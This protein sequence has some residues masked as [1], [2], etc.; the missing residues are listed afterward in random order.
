MADTDNTPIT[1]EEAAQM[2]AQL[3]Q[4]DAAQAAAVAADRAAKLKP[5]TDM[6]AADYWTDLRANIGSVAKAMVDESF[7]DQLR[8]LDTI[9]GN[10]AS[11][12]AGSVA[13][14]APPAS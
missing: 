3:Q 5:L 13:P 12:V 9:S 1:D 14:P 8:A 4:Y 11:I 6:L 7:Y 2:R 10:L